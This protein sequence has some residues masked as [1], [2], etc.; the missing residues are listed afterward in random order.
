MRQPVRI[1]QVLEA[2]AGGTRRHLDELIGALAGDEFDVHVVCALR[3]DPDFERSIAAYRSQ[4]CRVT[5]LHMTPGPAPLAD[6]AATLRLRRLLRRSRCDLLHL[7][8]S[9]AGFVGRLAARGLD[10]RVLYSPHY[11]P[12]LRREP[13]R[14]V[15][16]WIER[17]LAPGTDRLIAVSRAEGRLA[18]E[19]GLFAPESVRVL[20]NAVD[21]ARLEREVGTAPPPQAGAPRTFGLIGELRAQK[22]PFDLLEAVRLLRDRNSP[23][24]FV[25]PARGPW[26]ARVRRYLRRHDL[27]TRVELVPAGQS[28]A[29]V[30][31]RCQIA[32]LPSL[33]EGLPYALL[34]ALALRRPVIASSL[35]VFEDLVGRIE[36]R[37]LFPTGDVGA[38]AERIDLWS[39]LPLEEVDAVGE[40]GRQHVL[41]EHDFA[42]WGK[43]LR[44]LYRDEAGARACA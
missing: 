28:L 42:A 10:C 6:P 24:R 32:V 44:A 14:H 7:H 21:V 1:V 38:L 8:S 34:D 15:Y 16:R 36:P 35:P 22:N 3:R 25:L 19:S 20:P 27:A 30:Y 9:K 4:G 37:L 39:R 23:A 18:V 43:E 40:R 5:L 12:W 41:V 29:E 17:A 31:R 26:L 2:S 33:W 13:L 11:F